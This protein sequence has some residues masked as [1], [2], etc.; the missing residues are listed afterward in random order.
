VEREK[1]AFGGAKGVKGDGGEASQQD[2]RCPT[3]TYTHTHTHKQINDNE[4][5][6]IICLLYHPLSLSQ[7][8]HTRPKTMSATRKD[9]IR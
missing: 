4:I 5:I 6:I 2:G 8:T 9:H 1:A 7:D 3:H